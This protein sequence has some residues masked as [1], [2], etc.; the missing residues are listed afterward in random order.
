MEA[1]VFE[2]QGQQRIE[3]EPFSDLD[4]GRRREG[5]EAIARG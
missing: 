2:E 4:L 1:V 3:P 5:E